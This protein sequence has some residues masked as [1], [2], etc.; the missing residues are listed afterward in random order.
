MK[1]A[2]IRKHEKEDSWSVALMCKV[3]D[4]SS[5]GYYAWLSHKASP[6]EEKRKR[7]ERAVVLSCQLSH[8]I[9]GYRKTHRE[10]SETPETRCCAE[11]VRKIMKANGLRSRIKKT[12][13][14]TTDARHDRP[15]AP[16]LLERDFEAESPNEKWVSDITYIGTQEGWLYL[17]VILD[18]FS[19]RIVGWSMSDRIDAELVCEAFRSAVRLRPPSKGLILHSDRGAQYA[20]Q[21]FQDL[22]G[23]FSCRCSM[24]RKGDCW[25]NA[26]AESFFG[27]MKTEW[28]DKVFKT[29]DEAKKEV[30]QYIEMFYNPVRRHAS[31]DYMS[32]ACYERDYLS[33]VLN[34]SSCVA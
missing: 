33:R 20:S 5:S 14:R 8:R 1:Y 4:V 30:F 22:L 9:N 17:A 10:I 15:V 27:S 21:A 29:K 31:L 6:K 16:N 11:T 34:S 24:S 28:I 32:P 7:I 3:L 13:V 19:R 12:Y 23:I 2:W 26:M 25:D 18:C